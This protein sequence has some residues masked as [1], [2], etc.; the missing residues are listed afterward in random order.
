[1]CRQALA[2]KIEVDRPINTCF[3]GV[4]DAIQFTQER[5]S[6]FNPAQIV[7]TAYHAV[8]KTGIY[9]L[10]LKEWRKKSEAYQTWAIFK[11]VL[12]KDYHDLLEETKVASGEAGFHLS[13]EIQDIG[14]ALDHL[15]M[16]EMANKDIVS[17]L[18]EAVKVLTRIN[19]SLTT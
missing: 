10:S 5:K 3:Q 13:N 11:Q 6:S 4:D 18:T 12:A 17:R 16:V 8:N 15:A 2:E 7:Q 9:S 14:E 1:M 19:A